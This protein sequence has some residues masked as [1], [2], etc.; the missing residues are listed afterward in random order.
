MPRKS[1]AAQLVTLQPAPKRQRLQPP[2]DLSARAR[3]LWLSTL[4]ALPPGYVAPDQAPLLA[5]YVEH[6]A[7][8]EALRR[9]LDGLDMTAPAWTR[10]SAQQIAHSKAALA[11]ARSL[12][13]TSQ[14]RTEPDT[15]ARAI[16]READRPSGPRPWEVAS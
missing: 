13:L 8:A 14:S 1:A 11:H 12:R 5:A 7:M 2:D 9:A 6:T 15:A 4:H 3:E 10:L 16:Q